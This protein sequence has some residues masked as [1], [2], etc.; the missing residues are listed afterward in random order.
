MI[1]KKEINFILKLIFIYD[2][3]MINFLKKTKQ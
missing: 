1:V 2:G 3:L